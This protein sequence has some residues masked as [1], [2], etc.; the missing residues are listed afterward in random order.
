MS[1]KVGDIGRGLD[2]DD[3]QTMRRDDRSKAESHNSVSRVRM[4][5]NNL[6]SRSQI[7]ELSL[8]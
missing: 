7:V 4:T 5:S 8:R 6:L 1:L 2:D 3:F